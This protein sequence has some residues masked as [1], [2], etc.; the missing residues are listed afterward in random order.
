[1]ESKLHIDDDNSE[2]GNILKS[3]SNIDIKDSDNI[4]DDVK[5][6]KYFGYRDTPRFSGKL[7]MKKRP[8]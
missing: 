4:A 2:I 5:S 1:M 3:R 8:I 6:G 7:P